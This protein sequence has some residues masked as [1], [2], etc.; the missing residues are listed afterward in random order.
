MN[1][2]MTCL[3]QRDEIF[4]DV[5]ATVAPTFLVM[6]LKLLLA[7][8]V[9]AAPGVA[10]ED[11]HTQLLIGLHIEFDA[12]LFG[13]NVSHD[14]LSLASSRNACRCGR[15][16]NLNNRVTDCKGSSGLPSSRF[17]PARKSAQIISRQYPRDLSEP[18][19]KAAVSRAC[20]MTGI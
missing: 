18:S 17:A 13:A 9:L 19:I 15:G 8:A 3:T 11:L 16:R 2:K 20:S 5:A 4:F 1:E 6:N 12:G 7:A 14:A 10:F